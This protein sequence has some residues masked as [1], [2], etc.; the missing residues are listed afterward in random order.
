MAKAIEQ[1]AAGMVVGH[2]RLGRFGQGRGSVAQQVHDGDTVTVEGDG[3]FG[4][5]FLAVDAPEVSVPLPGTR[6]F[7]SLKNPRWQAVLADPLA[8]DLPPFAPPLTE[9]LRAHLAA[10]GGPD[11][12]GNHARLATQSTKALEATIS[13]DL[14][15]LGRTKEDFAFFLAFAGEVM[16]RY[17]R[18]LGYIHPDQPDVP[19]EQRLDSYNERLLEQGWV[20]PYFI[21]PNI[22]PF[23]RA[24]SVEGA[25]PAPGTAAE[26]AQRE[27]PL[28]DARR[29]VR[30]AR[31]QQVG[32]Y[33]A[34]DPLGLLAF[35]L[36]FVSRRQP[37][38]RWVVDLGRDDE[39]LLPPQAYV[40]IPNP[41]DRLFVPAEYVPLWEQHGWKRDV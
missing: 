39:V 31:E 5:R 33:Q 6:S 26:L 23:R 41:E 28:R 18:L 29:W 13:G 19:R 14:E 2:A 40:R 8:E 25:V 12:A 35:E 7:V 20:S 9:E 22:N 4:V 37:P 24:G 1:L 16:D 11:L 21:W 15:A 36:R 38:D 17:G 32:L 3:N 30:Q 34:G 10:A 27:K